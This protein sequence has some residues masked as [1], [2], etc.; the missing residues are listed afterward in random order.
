MAHSGRANE[1]A[2]AAH[3]SLV[4]PGGGNPSRTGAAHKQPDTGQARSAHVPLNKNGQAFSFVLN[5]GGMKTSE[6]ILELLASKNTVAKVKDWLQKNRNKG[7]SALAHFLCAALNIT[8]RL[9]K[10]AH[11]NEH[12]EGRRCH[13]DQEQH[14]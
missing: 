14:G 4:P 5:I 10:P 1:N 8:D 3:R 13:Q 12:H 7:R 11:T 9:G 2:G 6:T